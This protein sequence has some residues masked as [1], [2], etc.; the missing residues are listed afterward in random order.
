MYGTHVAD[1]LTR[2]RSSVRR[3]PGRIRSADGS[4]THLK[5]LCR[6]PPCRLASAPSHSVPSPGIEPGLRRSHSRVLVRHTPRTLR[7]APRRGIERASCR[8]VVCRALRYTRRASVST[9]TRTWI[10]TFGLSD[11]IL[12][13]IETLRADDWIRTSIERFT[14]PPPFSVEPRRQAGARGFEPRGAA[15]E[16]ASSPRRTLL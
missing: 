9:R 12:C 8:F 1:R 3:W 2:G 4:R 7:S 14:R 15:L 13:T 11:A 5:L 10:W 6:Q 16:T